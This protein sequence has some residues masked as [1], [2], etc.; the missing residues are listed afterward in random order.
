MIREIIRLLS[1]DFMTICDQSSASREARMYPAF[2]PKDGLKKPSV[3]HLQGKCG[4]RIAVVSCLLWGILIGLG[5]AGFYRYS[6]T[7]GSAAN[8]P[9]QWPVNSSLHLYADR[10]TLIMFAHPQ[11]SCTTASLAELSRIMARCS[12]RVSGYVAFIQPRSMSENWVK[13][14][15]WSTAGAIPGVVAVCDSDGIES[16]RFGAATSGQVLLYDRGGG[17]IYSGGITESRGHAGDNAGSDAI[18]ALLNNESTDHSNSPVF[19]CPLCGTPTE[20][21]SGGA[22]CHK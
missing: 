18:V 9:G 7:P 8:V 12:G 13:S 6:N 1:S 14:S 2:A 20:K 11:C 21:S 15:L 16:S 17:L 10:A 5:T 22:A 3:G 4:R 19:G